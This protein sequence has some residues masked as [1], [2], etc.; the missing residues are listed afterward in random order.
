VLLASF[1]LE[2][3]PTPVQ[4]FGILIAFSGIALVGSKLQGSVT[5]IGFLFILIA[6]ASKSVG[7]VLIKKIQAKNMFALVI[8]GNFIAFFPTLLTAFLIEGKAQML[9]NFAHFDLLTLAALC[10]LAYFSTMLG[11]GC[12]SWLVT[13]YPIATIAPYALLV[14]IVGF[15]SSAIVFQETIQP[16]QLLAAVLVILGLCINIWGNRMARIKALLQA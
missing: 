8:W 6:A 4:I 2:E 10:Y 16:W 7:N 15:T 11:Y 3:I 1:F 13:K 12:W 5:S 9:V 14:P